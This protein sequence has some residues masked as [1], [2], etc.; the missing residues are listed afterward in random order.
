MSLSS[1]FKLNH[2]AVVFKYISK[3]WINIFMY[4]AQR[5]ETYH[6]LFFKYWKVDG[7]NDC[8]RVQISNIFNT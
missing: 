4:S 8:E 3:L 7:P 6:M 2:S 5:L 1:Y